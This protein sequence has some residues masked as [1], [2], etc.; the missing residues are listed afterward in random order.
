VTFADDPPLR[1][2]KA[3]VDRVLREAQEQDRMLRELDREMTRSR[4]YL[5]KVRVYL[6]AWGAGAPRE[7]L[8]TVI[9]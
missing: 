6:V 2:S 3:E 9:V 5:G 1:V 8:L 4:E 7:G